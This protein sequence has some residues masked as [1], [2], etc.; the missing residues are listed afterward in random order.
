ML[1]S[2]EFV[3]LTLRPPWLGAAD[4]QA[5]TQEAPDQLGIMRQPQ[6]MQRAPLARAHLAQQC[7]RLTANHDGSVQVRRMRPPAQ[8]RHHTSAPAEQEP[9]IQVCGFAWLQPQMGTTPNPHE[10]HPGCR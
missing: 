10:A 5:C 2:Q 9:E 1:R 4:Q 3:P 7:H 6:R 8:G